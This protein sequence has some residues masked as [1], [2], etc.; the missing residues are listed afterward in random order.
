[1]KLKTNTLNKKYYIAGGVVYKIENT[2]SGGPISNKDT[3]LSNFVPTIKV[4]KQS[5]TKVD[6]AGDAWT[7][8][9]TFYL[10]S[11]IEI[12]DSWSMVTGATSIK[13]VDSNKTL[14]DYFF[15]LSKAELEAYI[16]K[17]PSVTFDSLSTNNKTNIPN[18][19]FNDYVDSEWTYTLEDDNSSK[20]LSIESIISNTK[21]SLISEALTTFNEKQAK[22]LAT[23]KEKLSK[24]YLIEV[25]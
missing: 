21:T 3:Q 12:G 2:T 16:A 5:K 15:E 14:V 10:D 4:T 6:D 24:T 18:W 13:K 19:V 20:R 1:M 9:E 7:E 23:Y 22:E 25:E 8:I 17:N 11:L